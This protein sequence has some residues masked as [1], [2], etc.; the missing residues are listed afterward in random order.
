MN[1]RLL[2]LWLLCPKE[3]EKKDLLLPWGMGRS[4]KE[5]FPEWHS[6]TEGDADTNGPLSIPL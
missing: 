4:L 5:F 3:G 6:T 2:N 1:Q